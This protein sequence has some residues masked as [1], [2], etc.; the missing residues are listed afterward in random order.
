MID[1]PLTCDVAESGDRDVRDL[2][3]VAARF[4]TSKLPASVNWFAKRLMMQGV[5]FM[6]KFVR[7]DAVVL[8]G[9]LIRFAPLTGVT[10][11]ESLLSQGEREWMIFQ[12][13]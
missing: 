1:S 6:P 3:A 10:P 12:P 13:T 2:V 11:A 9:R 5:P 8:N 7:A 4:R